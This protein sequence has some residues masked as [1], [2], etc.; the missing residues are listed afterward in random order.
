MQ[1]SAKVFN[2][3][4]AF[5]NISTMH[6]KQ[7]TGQ[8]GE[9]IAREFLISKGY[10]IRHCNWQFQH[11][12]LDIVAEY[13]GMLIVVEVKTRTNGFDDP[14]EAVTPRKQRNI[15]EAANAY[16]LQYNIL[17]E[18][19]FDVITVVFNQQSREVEHLEDAFYPRVR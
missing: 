8:L 14:R 10:N 17:K 13:L 12:E 3:N 2:F 11:K 6:E 18:T 16:V 9:S 7:K 15:V 19:R 1:I 5:I 4:K